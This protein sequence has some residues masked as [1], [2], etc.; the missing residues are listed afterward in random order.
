MHQHAKLFWTFVILALSILFYQTRNDPFFGDAISSISRSSNLIYNAEFSTIA[1]PKNLDPGHPTTSPLLHAVG[2][3]ILGKE[4]WV[5]HVLNMT[6]GVLV[7]LLF[8]KWGQ[9]LG[10][11]NSTYLGGLL[12]L[13][14]PLFV[15]QMVNP[16][17]HLPLTFFALG[18]V[19]SLSYGNFWQQAL[20]A[21]GLVLTHLQG[22]Y[23]LTP[24]WLWWFMTLRHVS[25]SKRVLLSAKILWLPALLFSAWVVYHHSLTGWYISS[26]D[27]MGHRGFPGIKGFI[28]NLIM[29]DWRIVDYG[30]IALWILPVYAV[31]RNR[32]NWEWKHPFSLLLVVFLFNSVTIGLTTKTGPMHRYLLPCL[33][34]L[35]MANVALLKDFK[36]VRFALLFVLLFSGHFWFY[37]GKVMGDATLSYRSVFPLLEAAKSEYNTPSLY[38]Y[39]PLSNA[40]DMTALHGDSA[41]YLP[42]YGIDIETVPYVLYSNISGDFSP[43][44]IALLE[45]SWPS[46]TYQKGYV[47]LEVYTNPNLIKHPISGPKRRQSSFEIWFINLKHTIKG[48]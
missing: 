47:F 6:F 20:F 27:Y 39:A 41:D 12:L 33:P 5:S 14:T 11:K 8:V 48:E 9:R 31:V 45:S 7:L 35:V 43:K 38:T 23:Y 16:N 40:S 28:I 15:S 37:P 36:P 22:L 21:S 2:W 32:I 18:F 25:F 29:A 1:Y 42:L 4:L 46:K 26:P 17:L 30:Q 24:I 19:Y 10:Y 34:F 3:K 13:I 44:E